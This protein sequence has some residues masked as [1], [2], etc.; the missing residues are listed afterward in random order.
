[1]T[2]REEMVLFARDSLGLSENVDTRLVPLEGRGSDRMYYRFFW[3]KGHS[4]ILVHYRTTR[5]ENA[6]YAN[7]ARYLIE[8]DIPVPPVINH[9]PGVCLIL[10]KDLGE[11]DLWQFR[12][13]PWA[14]RKSLYEKTLRI[15]HR[16]H[17]LPVAQFPAEKV[18]LT[19]P[20][21]PWLYRW[22]RDYFKT[23][24][25][26]GLCGLQLDADISDCLEAE[27]ISL[28]ERLSAGSLSLVH[29]DLQSQ[30]VMIYENEPF[31]ID[32]QGMRFG[33]RFYD[34]GSILCDPYVRISADERLDLLSFYY[35]L[36][37]PDLEWSTFQNS[38]WEAAAQRLMQ[39]L[40][41]YGFL[42]ITKG[43]K[44]YLVHI[45]AG[46]QNLRTAAEKANSLPTLLKV[47]TSIDTKLKI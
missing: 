17:S 4:A 19:D 37:N 6:Y 35:G 12:D 3:D 30:N 15:V 44:N 7:I 39:A 23:N 20:F 22:E 31:L 45:P 28:A 46:I 2:T 32:F 40:G 24:F 34:L 18:H 1:M 10:M 25:I 43:L 21:G 26:E 16:L 33:T 14:V 5:I 27:L 9:D 36:S 41:A 8:M 38:F 11:R 42:G 13:E 47:C 29:R